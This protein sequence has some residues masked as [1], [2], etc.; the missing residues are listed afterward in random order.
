MV[1]L[2]AYDL[3][4]SFRA[5]ALLAGCSYH[6]AAQ[7]TGC[8]YHTAAQLTGCPH[9]TVAKHVAA[10]DAGRPLAEPVARDKITDECLPKIEELVEKSRGRIRADV[11]HQKLIGMRFEGSERS[12]RRAMAQFKAAWKLGRVRVHR[13]WITESGGWLLWRILHNSHYVESAIM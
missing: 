10:R 8:S 1:S 2:E 5:A 11:T 13:P 12:T 6:T 3:T 4:K 7:L 9:H